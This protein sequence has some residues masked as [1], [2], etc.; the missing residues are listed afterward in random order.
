[1]EKI[2]LSV[3]EAAGLLGVSVNCIYMHARAGNI[4]HVKIGSRILFH[5]DRLED[6][7]KGEAV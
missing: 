5:R 2:T 1:M 6:W 7:L 4:P 3:K